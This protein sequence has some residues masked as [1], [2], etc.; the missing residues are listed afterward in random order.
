MIK[1]QFIKIK[2]LVPNARSNI[3]DKFK[4]IYNYKTYSNII[5]N[6]SSIII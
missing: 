6:K 4:Y 3:H 5:L 2:Y 1:I